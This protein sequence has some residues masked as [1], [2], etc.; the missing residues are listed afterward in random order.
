[1]GLTVREKAELVGTFRGIRIHL[2]ETL[3]RWVPTSPELEVKVLFGRHIWDTAQHADLLG[4]RSFELRAPL[5][6]TLQPADA[7]MQILRNVS[8]YSNSRDRIECFYNIVLPDLERRHA[9]YLENTDR[10]QDEPTVRIL[11]RIQ[12]D[13]QRMRSEAEAVLRDCPAL[14][15]T[16]VPSLAGDLPF[17]KCGLAEFVRSG[18]Q[19][20]LARAEAR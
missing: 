14:P 7:Y 17:D 5:H 11:E 19:S 8:A 18:A 6:Y 15:K 9:Y 20:T 12:A 2:M 10:L 3:A 16:S 13:D 1:M 4:K